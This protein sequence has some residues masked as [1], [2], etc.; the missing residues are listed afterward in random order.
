MSPLPHLPVL[1][2]LAAGALA[3]WAPL[4][5]ADDARRFALLVGANDG[6]PE[7][8]ELRY[9]DDDA[10]AVHQVLRE[11]GGLSEQDTELLL[12]PDLATLREAME[13]LETRLDTTEGRKEVLFY[14]SGHSDELGLLV[15]G[16]RLPWAELRAFLD[17]LDAKVRMAVLDSCASGA[18]IRSKGGQRVAPFLVD[19]GTTVDGLAF[20]TSSAKDEVSQEADRIGGSYFTHYLTTGLR[21]AADRSGDGRVTL[22]EAYD[23]AR[24]ETLRKTELTRFGP[25]HANHEFDLSGSG[26]LVLTDLGTTDATLVLEADVVGQATVRDE[27]GHLVAE[28]HKAEGA[29]TH[30]ALAAG[31][32]RVTVS[33]EGR[34]GVA[35]VDVPAQ[36][37]VPVALADLSW[38]EGEEAVARGASGPIFRPPTPS[39]DELLRVQLVPGMP[40]TPEDQVDRALFGVVAA[41]THG[42]SGIA[43]TG[44]WLAVDGPQHGHALT[45]GAQ[46]TEELR[47]SQW[48]LGVNRAGGAT[49][50][51]QASLVGNLAD[52][53]TFLG[54][55]STFGF[56]WLRGHADGGQLGAVNLAKGGLR[57]AQVGAVNLAEGFSGVQLGLINIGGDVS[58]TQLGVINV[59][60]DVSGLQLGLINV[61]RDVR[62]T[63]LGLLSFEKEGRHDLLVYAS[64]T[65]WVNG[66]LRLG[67]DYLY[68]ALGGGGVPG[69]Q[70]HLDGGFGVHAPITGPL[71]M[72]FDGIVAA[73]LP[74]GVGG[75]LTESTITPVVRGRTTVGVQA[76]QEFAPFVGVALD[77]A[78]VPQTQPTEPAPLFAPDGY[79]EGRNSV[80][81]LSP[82]VFGGVQF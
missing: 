47:G 35:E 50:G 28:L 27:A 37:S 30:L 80:A 23:F 68:T 16:E 21:G 26:D 1:L 9:A 25:Q 29:A 75:P 49:R 72:D 76:L 10:R 59:A 34:Y 81:V 78:V 71:W 64:N 69:V 13:A 40:P 24:E 82:S 52:T 51:V 14:Y 8:V 62:G 18:L 15:G 20:I 79:L 12:D 32:Y 3:S 44:V 70:V 73:Y 11:L 57:G 36:S 54:F 43:V 7:R 41:D 46:R 61:A 65:D 67:G 31:D 4:A 56:N 55:Q 58:G 53:T 39:T 22:T 17:D 5:H 48:A 63:P 74:T 60:H 77:V 19:E 42:L 66:E 45:L 2:G 6:G 33:G 38:F